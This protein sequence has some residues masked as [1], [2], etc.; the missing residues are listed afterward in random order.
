L[1]IVVSQIIDYLQGLTGLSFEQIVNFEK[2]ITSTVATGSPPLVVAS[3]TEVGNLKSARATR[4]TV[5]SIT[6]ANTH[7]GI[8]SITYNNSSSFTNTPSAGGSLITVVRKASVPGFDNGDFQLFRPNSG[9]NTTLYLRNWYTPTTYSDWKVIYNSGNTNL[10]TVD[11]AAKD[12]ILSKASGAGVKVEGGTYGWQDIIGGI[13]PSSSGG[14]APNIA[15]WLG[16]IKQVSFG[17]SGL[18][19]IQ[20]NFHVLHDYA[21][22]T[23]MFI[24]AHWSVIAAATG[25]VVWYFEISYAKGYNQAAFNTPIVVSVYQAAGAVHTHQIAEV[26]MSGAGGVV[27]ITSAN[28]SITAG[29]FLIFLHTGFFK[30]F[31]FIL[32]SFKNASISSV[33]ITCSNC[34]TSFSTSLSL[35]PIAQKIRWRYCS[36]FVSIVFCKSYRICSIAKCMNGFMCSTFVHLFLNSI[37]FSARATASGFPVKFIINPELMRLV[38]CFPLK[39]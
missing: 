8:Q 34:D 14:T 9:V 39:M 15:T 24:H 29:S 16:N 17:T 22:N 3:T 38:L 31:A 36:A 32:F 11:W 4:L 37:P 1:D 7:P 26:Q 13:L 28:F 2:Q 12:L 10:N 27:P 21:P 5:D 33:V 6:D 25:D 35:F 20:N 18:V 19:E 23:D 30:S